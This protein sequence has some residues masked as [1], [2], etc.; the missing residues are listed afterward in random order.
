[1]VFLFFFLL[2]ASLFLEG[3]VT[4]LPL[5]FICFLCL[6][7]FMRNPMLFV[8]AFIAGLFLD[9]FAVRTLGGTSI[10][11][12]VSIFLIFLYQRKY[13]INTYPFVLIASFIGAVVY[14]V[15]FG[16]GGAVIQA[17]LSSL[18]AVILFASY[19]TYNRFILS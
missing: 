1:M 3:I 6:T 8:F 5:V 12:L 9:T 10:F 15:V 13:E 17:S 4:T 16:Y 18:I 14:A 11:L 7:I 2:F 19:R